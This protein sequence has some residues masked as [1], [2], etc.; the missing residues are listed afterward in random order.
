MKRLEYYLIIF[1]IIFIACNETKTSSNENE[2]TPIVSSEPD[3]KIVN[4]P[5]QNDATPI[6]KSMESKIPSPSEEGGVDFW[7]D[8][9]CKRSIPKPTIPI[10]K[11]DKSYTFNLNKKQG[12]GK[13]VMMLD[14][15]YKLD[16]TSKGCNSVMLTYN[17]FFPAKDLDIQDAEAVSNKVIELIQKTVRISN[18]PINLKKKI[19]PLQ[20]AVEQIGPFAVGEEFILSD[21]EIKETFVLERVAAKGPQVFLSYYF[22]KGPI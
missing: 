22:S 5:K 12:F 7:T 9:N 3:E 8:N 20:M 16:V 2:G 1:C 21:G 11:Q 6:T 18:P 14:N 13:E 10:S 15:K 4:I 19:T 17:Y